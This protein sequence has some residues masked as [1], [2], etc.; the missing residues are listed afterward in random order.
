L[1][2]LQ[3]RTED[4]LLLIDPTAVPPITERETGWA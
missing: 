4:E 2:L 3:T 1:R